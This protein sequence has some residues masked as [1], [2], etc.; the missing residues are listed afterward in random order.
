MNSYTAEDLNFLKEAI[1]EAEAG[2]SEGGIPIGAVLVISEKILGRGHNMRVQSGDPTAHAEIVCLRSAGRLK[3]YKHATL[4]STLMPCMM[5]GGA[6]VQFGIKRVVVGE[7][8]SFEGSEH[9]MK[10][11]GVEVVNLKDKVCFSLLQK[12]IKIHPEVWDEDIGAR[13]MG[14]KVGAGANKRKSA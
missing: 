4:Y 9:L 6:I 5:C 3:G 13:K 12:Y 7:S 10:Q 2:F 1:K 8:K 11:H 14:R